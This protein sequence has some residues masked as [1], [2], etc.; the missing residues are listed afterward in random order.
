MPAASAYSTP[1]AWLEQG[2]KIEVRGLQTSFGPL[3]YTM[4]S[5]PDAVHVQLDVPTGFTGPLRLRVRLPNGQRMVAATVNSTAWHAFAGPETLDL[6]GQSGHIE[7]W[8]WR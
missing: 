2:K 5:T 6:T 8:I 3:S 4:D 1:R 7:V